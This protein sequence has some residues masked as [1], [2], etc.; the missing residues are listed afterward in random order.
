MVSWNFNE[1]MV[2][3]VMG[4]RSERSA[5]NYSRPDEEMAFE[6]RKGIITELSQNY[7]SL[8]EKVTKNALACPTLTT[9]ATV[10]IRVRGVV[11][12]G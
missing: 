4:H 7:H 12:S 2:Q 5:Q 10:N 11:L 9:S 1:R 3:A 6:V 8:P